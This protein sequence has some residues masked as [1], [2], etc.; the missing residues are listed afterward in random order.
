MSLRIDHA[1]NLPIVSPSHQVDG[2]AVSTVELM[3]LSGV[4]HVCICKSACVFLRGLTKVV[5]G[6]KLT[7][8]L[9]YHLSYSI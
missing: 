8:P 1:T 3:T 4:A 6:H 5:R 2:L 7:S 9:C